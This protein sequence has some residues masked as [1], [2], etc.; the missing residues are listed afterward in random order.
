MN[1]QEQPHRRFNP[2]IGEWVLVSPHRTQRPWLGKTESAAPPRPPEYDSK[3]YLCPGNVRAG[4]AVNPRYAETF[5]FV[6]DYSALL[7][8]SQAGSLDE[9]GII[10]AE[11][12]RGICKVM[13]FTPRHDL[14]I[15]LM[16]P[17]GIARV[18]GAWAEEYRQI[19]ADPN[20]AYVQIFENRGEMMG[21]SN[22]H[23]HCQ[24]WSNEHVPVLPEREG[25]M[26]SAYSRDRGTCL[27]CDYLAL[28]R[29]DGARLVFENAEFVVLVPFWAVWPFETLILPKRHIHS[30]LELSADDRAKLAEAMHQ[31]C[32]RYDNLFE[33]SF[34]YSMGIHQAPTDASP[35]D[36]WHLHLHYY[37]PLLRSATVRKFMVGYEMLATPQRDITAES[38]AERLRSLPA[39][40]FTVSAR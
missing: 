9:S 10:R 2:L 21:A 36:A 7:P 40:H 1:L 18:I 26:L 19:G 34:P 28:E 3:C 30:L 27:L 8:D 15:A 35:G 16:Q 17:D 24:I 39:R 25:A 5:V 13:C 37:P 32:V 4:G 22:P 38:A 31:L 20:I 29:K 12:E 33:T 23:P 11:A 14:T 6:N